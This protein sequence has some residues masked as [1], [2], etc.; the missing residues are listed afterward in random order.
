MD[1]PVK[2][3]QQNNTSPQFMDIQPPRSEQ[4]AP[5]FA[6]KAQQTEVVDAPQFVDDQPE[7]ST[8]EPAEATPL[9][10][11]SPGQPHTKRPVAAILVAVVVAV[12]LGGVSF[13]AYNNT[14]Q[15]QTTAT[16]TPASQAKVETAKPAD[17]DNATKD[18]DATLGGVNESSDLNTDELSDSSLSL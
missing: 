17:V 10:A 2:D 8:A 16:T 14:K 11:Q 3:P 15:P 18:I 7:P 13:V 1:D 4:P 6:E 9:I 5:G 12:T